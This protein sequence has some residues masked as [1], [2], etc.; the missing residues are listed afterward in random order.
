MFREKL[1]KMGIK[2]IVF[3]E[4]KRPTYHFDLK[5]RHTAER[6]KDMGNIKLNEALF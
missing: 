6:I 2:Q 4:L 1:V 5:G 3:S